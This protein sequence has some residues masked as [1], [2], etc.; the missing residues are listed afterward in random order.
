[1]INIAEILKDAPEGTKLYSPVLGECQL[2]KMIGE[3]IEIKDSKGRRVSVNAFGQY[4]NDGG[5]CLL[6]PSKENRDWRAF[7]H[8]TSCPFKPFD[9][10][11][12]RDDDEQIWHISLFERFGPEERYP[13]RCVDCSWRQCIPYNE[14]TAKLIGTTDDYA[15]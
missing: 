13:Y 5:E 4:F 7:E 12:V 8:K 15:G 1:M 3:F 9:K 14:E 10:V 11:L 2:G 6:F